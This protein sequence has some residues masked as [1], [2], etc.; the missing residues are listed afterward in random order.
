MEI[1]KGKCILTWKVNLCN[2]L[3]VQGYYLILLILRVLNLY[4]FMFTVWEL[5]KE[6]ILLQWDSDVLKSFQ[7]AKCL[8]Q[9]SFRG[10]GLS[11][12][13]KRIKREKLQT[14]TEL[15]SPSSCA[16]GVRVLIFEFQMTF[17]RCSSV[18][19]FNRVHLYMEMISC[20]Q[21]WQENP[22]CCRKWCSQHHQEAFCLSKGLFLVYLVLLFNQPKCNGKCWRLKQN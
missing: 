5:L 11:L 21:E 10:W 22:L 19:R 4:P 3:I 17:H 18:N 9:V 6:I 1:L 8:F 20:Q 2:F 12:E 13:R 15:C 14:N 16:L 7:K